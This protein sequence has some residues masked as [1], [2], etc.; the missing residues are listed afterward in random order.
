L[1]REYTKGRDFFD[2]GW[3]LSRFKD[4]KPNIEFL[5]NALSQTGWKKEMPTAETWIKYV[6]QVVLEADWKKVRG[7]VQNFLENPA[8]LDVFS[9]ENLLVLTDD[10]SS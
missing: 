1:S 10:E 8:D 5:Q 2:L 6:R 3:Y 7:D 9:K 4:L